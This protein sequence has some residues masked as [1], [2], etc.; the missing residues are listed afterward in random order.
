[1]NTAF[2]GH[3]NSLRLLSACTRNCA[4]FFLG[5][6][7]EKFSEENNWQPPTLGTRTERIRPKGVTYGRF[8]VYIA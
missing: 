1:M 7:A 6:L 3:G 2:R 4:D 5:N 8:F